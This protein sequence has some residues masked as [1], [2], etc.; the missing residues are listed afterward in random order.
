MDKKDVD[1]MA[2]VAQYGL[3]KYIGVAFG[4]NN[5]PETFCRARVV[6]MKAVKWQQ[7]SVYIDDIH[8]FLKTPKKQLQH[9]EEVLELLNNAWMTIKLKKCLLFIEIID[10][11]VHIFARNKLLVA[12]KTTGAIKV[13]QYPIKV[14]KFWGFLRLC[15]VYQRFVLNFI[16]L[17]SF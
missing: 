13:L 9:I 11:F 17:A 4:L 5:A 6:I 8:I 7:V 14:S 3:F 10:H 15:S 12:T 16:K 1:M 2:F